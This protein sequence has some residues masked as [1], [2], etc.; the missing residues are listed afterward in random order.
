[1]RRIRE[2]SAQSVANQNAILTFTDKLVDADQQRDFDSEQFDVDVDSIQSLRL[3][4]NLRLLEAR[5]R[6]R[7]E[8]RDESNNECDE[9]NFESE[10]NLNDSQ[11]CRE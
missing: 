7:R 9:Q 10:S 4:A 1:M 6:L 8:S 3:E 5:R 11:K 2:G